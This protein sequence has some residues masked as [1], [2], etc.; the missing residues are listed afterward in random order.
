[1][2]VVVRRLVLCLQMHLLEGGR[3]AR[4]MLEMRGWWIWKGVKPGRKSGHRVG[5]K[6]CH[7]MCKEAGDDMPGRKS[8]A[9]P[10]I[11]LFT[12]EAHAGSKLWTREGRIRVG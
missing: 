3:M 12:Q 9:H 8:K 10:P 6:T 1:M 7:S 4:W 5:R 2:V 11:P